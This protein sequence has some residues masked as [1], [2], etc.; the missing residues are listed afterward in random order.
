MHP[1]RERLARWFTPMAKRMPLSPNAITIVALLLNV[2]A[3]I[4]LAYGARRPWL[5]LLAIV[6]IAVS[7]LADALDGIVARVQNKSSRF[8]DFLD[9]CADRARG[10]REAGHLADARQESAGEA[11]GQA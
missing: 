5:F 11:G 8:G 2:V 6:I 10:Q 4:C 7:G 1:W 3:G 9:H